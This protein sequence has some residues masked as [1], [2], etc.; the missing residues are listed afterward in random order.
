MSP[1]GQRSS[2]LS[3]ARSS[4]PTPTVPGGE[5][6]RAFTLAMAAGVLV[7]DRSGTIVLSNPTAQRLIDR[8]EDELVGGNLGVP[9][10][11]DGVTQ[12]DVALRDGGA[13]AVEM[14]VTETMWSTEPAYVVTLKDVSE[15]RQ[16]A[17]ELDESEERFQAVFEE[18]P[19]GL[20]ILSSDYRFLRVNRALSSML[21]YDTAELMTLKVADVSRPEDAEAQAER[22]RQLVSGEKAGH[23]VETWL[24]T[25][26]GEMRRGHV[27]SAVMGGR[28]GSQ[29]DVICTVEDITERTE[30]LA[31]VTYLA[32][33]DELTGLANRALVMD[34]LHLAQARAQR[35]GTFVGLLFLDLDGFKA[36][37]D[38]LGHEAGDA[39]L[40]EVAR[41][42]ES[43]LRPSD[44]AARLGGDEF[45]VCCDDLGADATG[46]QAAALHVVDRIVAVLAEPMDGSLEPTTAS[47]G[48]ALVRGTQQSSDTVLR[49]ADQAMYRAKQQGA[50]CFELFDEALQARAADRVT[51][52]DELGLAL[53]R[54][55]LVVHYQPIASLED[56]QVIGAEALVRWDHPDRGIL[57]PREFLDVAEESGLI[58]PLGDWVLKR[59]CRDVARWRQTVRQDLLVT[60]NA[61]A[62]QLR[63]ETLADSIEEALSDSGLQAGALE[64]ELTETMLIEATAATLAQLDALRTLGVRIG[65][66]DFGTGYASLSC[67]RR[68]PVDFVKIDRSFVA[69]LGESSDDEAIVNAIVDLSHALGLQVVTEGVESLAQQSALQ[70]M[71]CDFAQGW[72]FGRPRTAAQFAKMLAPAPC[73]FRESAPA[74]ER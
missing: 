35:S 66:D 15:R 6:L 56:G 52:R 23:D 20:A 65:L 8:T 7:V 60:V 16:A 53:E 39:L 47:I 46:A 22:A 4:P 54:D 24:V 21:G 5:I 17:G 19:I 69:G 29:S 73:S 31:R 40:I 34:R 58:V 13:R 12:I 44:T 45:L 57:L 37:N 32:L 49:N 1:P 68:L 51:V 50:A 62:R 10:V 30:S 55:E 27:T 61:S 71:G 9:L 67:L 70:E 74:D 63:D 2:T 42:L 36:V 59:A 25:K 41:R 38:S 48:I 26:A 72:H 64:I 18:S 28:F 33:H 14:Q 43:V 3:P 11:P